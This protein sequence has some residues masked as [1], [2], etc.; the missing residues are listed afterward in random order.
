LVLV[1]VAVSLILALAVWLRPN[2]TLLHLLVAVAM[3]V[4]AA[5]DIRE[6]IH[7][8]EESNGGLLLFASLVAALHLTAG[9]QAL[10][11]SRISSRRMNPA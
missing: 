8:G 9:A 6:A 7:Q 2:H 3:L 11:L 5:L 10:Y 4:F 1:A